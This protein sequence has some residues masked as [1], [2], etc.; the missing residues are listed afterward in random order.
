MRCLVVTHSLFFVWLHDDS[1]LLKSN[2]LHHRITTAKSTDARIP[3]CSKAIAKTP[4]GVE[5]AEADTAAC[6]KLCL[7]LKDTCKDLLKKESYDVCLIEPFQSSEFTDKCA[8]TQG[9]E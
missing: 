3:D 5:P 1:F 7:E 8:F 2:A 6:K 9:K 4:H